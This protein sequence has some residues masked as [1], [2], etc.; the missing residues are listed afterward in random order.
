MMKIYVVIVMFATT[1]QVT[2][3]REVADL[4]ACWQL[5]QEVLAQAQSNDEMHESAGAVSV[6]CM[7]DWGGVSKQSKN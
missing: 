4:A 6:G 2:V 3:K 1:G 7:T 5:A